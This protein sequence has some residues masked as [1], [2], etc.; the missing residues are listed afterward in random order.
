MGNHLV[1]HPGLNKG[2]NALQ[3][4]ARAARWKRIGVPSR[5]PVTGWTALGAIHGVA[6]GFHYQGLVSDSCP[7]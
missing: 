2:K 7:S 1:K 4:A 6:V 3:R 5:C